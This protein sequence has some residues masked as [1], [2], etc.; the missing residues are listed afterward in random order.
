MV[1][2]YVLGVAE[3]C[4]RDTWRSVHVAAT[5]AEVL[6]Q[7][8]IGAHADQASAAGVSGYGG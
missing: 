4:T 7:L 6:E 3:G 1:E 8:W 5:P 2:A